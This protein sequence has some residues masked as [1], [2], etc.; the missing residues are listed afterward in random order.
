MRSVRRDMPSDPGAG[1]EPNREEIL[2][3]EIQG[4]S[5]E[6]ILEQRLGAYGHRNWIVVADSAYPE[7]VATGLE[8]V[9]T[10]CDHF[11]ILEKVFEAISAAPHV[12]PIVYLDA[13]LP[14]LDED[15]APGAGA[16]KERLGQIVQDRVVNSLPHEEIITELDGAASLFKVLLLKSNL[17]LPYTS[18]FIQLD[19]GYWSEEAEDRLRRS[20][21]AAQLTENRN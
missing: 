6:S 2:M 9:I 12:R 10:G 15:D 16:F 7:Q 11:E 3:T 4:N 17:T 21:E 8:T 14:Y 1:N 18:V 19:C 20:I 5:W 13:E